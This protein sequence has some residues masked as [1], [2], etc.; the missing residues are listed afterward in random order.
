MSWKPIVQPH[1]KCYSQR[2]KGTCYARTNTAL[3]ESLA[4]SVS[5]THSKTH[6]LAFIESALTHSLSI[7]QL[8]ALKSSG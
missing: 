2:G 6:L 3:T 5:G 7:K 8:I 4:H 1:A